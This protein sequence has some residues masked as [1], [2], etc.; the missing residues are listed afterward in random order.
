MPNKVI[1]KVID[2]KIKYNVNI[3]SSILINYSSYMYNCDNEY[4]ENNIS[5]KGPFNYEIYEYSNKQIDEDDLEV[6]DQRNKLYIHSD[7]NIILKYN[8]NKNL[9]IFGKYNH[10]IDTLNYND[11]LK[12]YKYGLLSN[13][14]YFIVNDNFRL[15]VIPIKNMYLDLV[16]GYIFSLCIDNTTGDQTCLISYKIDING[17]ICI[18]EFEDYFITAEYGFKINLNMYKLNNNNLVVI[19]NN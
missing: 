15:D 2:N 19:Q 1:F 3:P 16:S 8:N 18:L 6:Y 9:E 11:V 13:I 10:K 14:Q 7:T 5:I 4:N 17:N 12:A